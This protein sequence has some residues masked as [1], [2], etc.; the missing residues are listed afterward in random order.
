MFNTPEREEDSDTALRKNQQISTLDYRCHRTSY[1][2]NIS[3]TVS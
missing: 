3:W 1:M 2:S